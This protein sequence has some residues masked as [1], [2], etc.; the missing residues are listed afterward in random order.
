MSKV[1]T[2]QDTAMYADCPPDD[3]EE[4]GPHDAT[5]PA[6]TG[7]F[8]FGVLFGVGLAVLG[9]VVWQSLP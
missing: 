5:V 7:I 4:D 6:L 9:V 8:L 3:F 2:T 1:R